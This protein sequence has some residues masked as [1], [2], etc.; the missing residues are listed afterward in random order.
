[1]A[2]LKPCATDKNSLRLRVASFH[3]FR[4]AAIGRSEAKYRHLTLGS[5]MSRVV[6]TTAAGIWVACLCAG[7][8]AGQLP[9]GA[10]PATIDYQQHVHVILAAKCLS[11]HS[12]ERRSGGL[13]LTAYADVLEGGRSG[14]A[15]RPGSSARSL[16]VQR[17]TGEVTPQMPLGRAALSPGEIATIRMWIDEG[18]RATVTS[19]PANPKW[20]AP[21]ALSRPEVPDVV[22]GEWMAPVDRFVA[23]YLREH[24]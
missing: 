10:V 14:A 3:R 15:I 18:A 16:L 17:I 1:M 24:G 9:P 11:C 2:G 13:S 12:A 20:E 19:A 4:C 5:H 6:L 22:W 8:Y 21:L 23:R 7:I